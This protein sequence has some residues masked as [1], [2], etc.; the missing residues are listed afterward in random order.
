VFFHMPAEKGQAKLSFG[1]AL[2]ALGVIILLIAFAIWASAPLNVPERLE[3]AFVPTL[4]PT[5][6][7]NPFVPEQSTQ[8][9]EAVPILLPETPLEET[10]T[11]PGAPGSALPSFAAVFDAPNSYNASIPGEPVRIIIPKLNIDAAVHRSGLQTLFDNGLRYFQWAVPNGFA[12]GWHE[13][14]APLGQPGNTVLNGH[15]NIYGEVFRDLVELEYGD[16][17]MLYDNTGQ[18]YTYEIQEQELLPETGQPISVRIENA[19]WIEATEDER[20]T[21]I[22]CW[23]YATN[24]YRVVL[25]ARPVAQPAGG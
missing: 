24:A 2:M 4:T 1:L 20:V 17:F 3:P 15:N 7:P 6:A 19:R 14:S 22:S 9:T 16:Q 8:P 10:G 18:T 23:P 21:L 5:S 11:L 12:A 13:T 25:I